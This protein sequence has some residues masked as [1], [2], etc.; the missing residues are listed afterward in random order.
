MKLILLSRELLFQGTMSCGTDYFGETA[1]K[2]AYITYLSTLSGNRTI[3]HFRGTD[4]T[5][6]NHA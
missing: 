1:V 6:H 4:K 5:I 2:Q 3:T